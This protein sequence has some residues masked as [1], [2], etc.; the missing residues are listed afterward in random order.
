[1]PC[2][3][4][5]AEFFLG[6]LETYG[7]RLLL[8][9]ANTWRLVVYLGGRL[10]LEC[11]ASWRRALSPT[12]HGHT[13]LLAFRLMVDLRMLRLRNDHVGGMDLESHMA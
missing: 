10:V 5:W 13:W 3:D 11:W 8:H 12:M 1:M 9:V 6:A 2:F 4:A 7:S